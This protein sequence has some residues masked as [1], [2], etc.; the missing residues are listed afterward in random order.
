MIPFLRANGKEVRYI[1]A[2]LYVTTIAV[3]DGK[4]DKATLTDWLHA[5]ARARRPAS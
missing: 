4:I 3:A 5:H 2:D 1:E